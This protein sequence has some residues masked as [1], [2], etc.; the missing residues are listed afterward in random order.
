MISA[1]YGE[2]NKF[3]TNV[4][5]ENWKTHKTLIGF[6]PDHGCHEIDGG[7]GSHGLYMPEDMNIVH[8]Y[9]LI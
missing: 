8:F 4:N 9:G 7:C 5:R 1:V 2:L 6:A 3:R